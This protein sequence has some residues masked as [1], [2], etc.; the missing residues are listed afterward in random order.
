MARSAK[1]SVV[2]F[3]YI[4]AYNEMVF[5]QFIMCG[6][7]ARVPPE[8]IVGRLIRFVVSNHFLLTRIRHQKQRRVPSDVQK[9]S[10]T[11]VDI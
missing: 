11:L 8:L 9:I 5:P 1:R 6:Q 4:S 7:D 10:C 3:Q 2:F